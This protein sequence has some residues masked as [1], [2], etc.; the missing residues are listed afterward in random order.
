MAVHSN[1]V[2]QKQPANTLDMYVDEPR[3]KHNSILSNKTK[4]LKRVASKNS[5]SSA[6]STAEHMFK[7][8]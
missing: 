1:K 8:R 5:A 2:S 4:V 6:A 3:E 7:R